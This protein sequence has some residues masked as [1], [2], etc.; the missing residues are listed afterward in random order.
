MDAA[1]MKKCITNALITLLDDKDI[2]RITAVDLA[3]AANISRATL[4]RYY[5]SVEDVIDELESEQLEGM[6]DVS[7]YYISQKLNLENLDEPFPPVVAIAQYVFD[8][9]DFFLA[10][11]GPH[12][13]RRFVHKWHQVIREFYLGK[14]AFEGLVNKDT[15][16]YVEFAIAGSDAV[17]RYWLEEQSDLSAEQV[18]PIVQKILYGP[19]LH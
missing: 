14:L 1:P 7:R 13:D 5:G 16:W 18:A 2:D 6:R 10:I 11:T 17:L 15:R 4:Y 8:N 12:G 19:F 3:R 9:R